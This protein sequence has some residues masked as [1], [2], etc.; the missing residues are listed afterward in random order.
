MRYRSH[1]RTRTVQ[2]CDTEGDPAATP[3]PT[4][5][6]FACPTLADGS[7]VHALPWPGCSV[8]AGMLCPGRDALCWPGC[9]ALAR[10][11][12]AVPVLCCVPRVCSLCRREGCSSRFARQPLPKGRGSW[13]PLLVALQLIL[14]EMAEPGN[15]PGGRRGRGTS[16]RG[17]GSIWQEG[18]TWPLES[19]D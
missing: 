17:H 13:A 1:C 15:G 3:G 8:L 10:M 4:A 18:R 6:G 7:H 19:R 16:V 11:L 5:P 14:G 9:S 2:R 12:C